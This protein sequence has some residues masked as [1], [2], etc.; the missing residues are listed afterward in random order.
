MGNQIRPALLLALASA[1][2]STGDQ[3]W[4]PP[5]LSGT[6]TGGS[7]PLVAGPR[8]ASARLAGQRRLW[9]VEHAEVHAVLGA[10]V[11]RVTTRLRVVPRASAAA[12]ILDLRGP[13]VVAVRGV[14]GGSLAYRSTGNQLEV[15]LGRIA[16]A[17]SCVE[18]EIETELAGGDGLRIDRDGSWFTATSNA[19]PG[20]WIPWVH[21]PLDRI[22]SDLHLDVPEGWQVLA[23]GTA[24][25]EV[26]A[27]GRRRVH[28]RRTRPHGFGELV[29][30]AGPRLFEAQETPLALGEQQLAFL[31]RWSQA[32]PP[33]KRAATIL[34][35]DLVEPI[36]GG[37]LMLLPESMVLDERGRRDVVGDPLARA[38]SRRWI[39]DTVGASVFAGEADPW[40]LDGLARQAE[41]DWLMDRGEEAAAVQ[42][43]ASW[44]GDELRAPLVLDQ[45]RTTLGSATYAEGLARFFGTARTS[46]DPDGALRGAMDGVTA[47]DLLPFFEAWVD[48]PGLADLDITWTHDAERGRVLL[49]VDQVHELRL[50]A[51]EAY[52]IT[53]GVW[54][55]SEGGGREH[56][57]QLD[58]RRSLIE[59]PAD[60]R[61]SWLSFD[62]ERQLPGAVRERREA[63]A[64]FGLASE[65]PHAPARAASV[66]GLV[67]LVGDDASAAERATE[68]EE[69]LLGML[70]GDAAPTVRQ[71]AALG[72]SRL[73]RAGVS[74][75]AIR[76]LCAAANAD[77]ST[78]VR[79]FALQGLS[80][81]HALQPI[82]RGALWPTVQEA[83]ATVH[84]WSTLDAALRLG[85]ALDGPAVLALLA[86]GLPDG[87]GGQEQA[88]AAVALL[89]TGA[90]RATEFCL[91]LAGDRSAGL[92]ARLAGLQ[93]LGELLAAGAGRVEPS[94]RET[95]VV[96][97][98]DP[99]PAVARE[100]AAVLGRLAQAG[101][102]WAQ[103]VL[104]RSYSGFSD[105]G[106]RRAVEAAWSR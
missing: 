34:V 8:E 84:S 48:T 86:D 32:P 19:G 105:S 60:E 100:A 88:A 71:A 87:P 67:K 64:W 72:I 25:G 35:H 74:A 21:A 63:R 85:A 104:A 99:Q 9:N 39:L 14:D 38:W 76:G 49:R 68:V 57:V 50:G 59:I 69:Q 93:G 103:D 40:W 54:L 94:M 30:G 20:E 92:A 18:I 23:A 11:A 51:P 80:R 73:P 16:L 47:F 95:L 31:T 83:V 89:A 75:A 97:T 17:G 10:E 3:G 52:P 7:T 61:P 2:S 79:H 55:H 44:H 77:D 6:G 26:S 27:Q 53:V 46:E 24:V 70:A 56:R 45:L 106:Q 78:H 1:C 62:P 5:G 58:R 41:H 13:E 66:Q 65:S 29:F 98:D 33:W 102:R 43:R 22:T 37:G 101:D 82:E 91:E 42:L 96:A 90:P 15:Q 4:R 81:L 28:Y 12:V 36:G